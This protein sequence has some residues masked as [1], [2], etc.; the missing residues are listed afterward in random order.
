MINPD[1]MTDPTNWTT[2]D[3]WI[4][5]REGLE[6][7]KTAPRFTVSSGNMRRSTLPGWP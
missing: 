4:F 2:V 5:D 1:I 6:R 7:R 3:E